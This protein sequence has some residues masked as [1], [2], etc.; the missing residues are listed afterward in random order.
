MTVSAETHALEDSII[1]EEI[2]AHLEQELKV[3]IRSY[4]AVHMGFRNWKWIVITQ[5]GKLFV[6]C[7]HPK[8]YP[9]TDVKCRLTIARS[10]SIQQIVHEQAKVCPAILSQDGKFIFESNSGY[11]YVV[12]EHYEGTTPAGAGRLDPEMMFRFGQAAGRMHSV[13][14]RHPGEGEPWT[15]TLETMQEKWKMQFERAA[16]LPASKTRLKRVLERQGQL[17][18][19]LDLSIFHHLEPGWAHWDLWVDNMLV[20]ADGDVCFVDFDTIQFGYQEIDVA[21]A[22]LSAALH[23]G[24]LRLGPTAAFLRGYREER[25]FPLGRLS[26]SLKLLWC[27]EAHWWLKTEMDAFSAPPKRFAEE[28]IWLMEHWDYL[29]GWFGPSGAVI[30]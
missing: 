2:F 8:R 24:Q 17:L 6:K 15:P 11:F 12:M 5:S 7:Y 10:L 30:K 28:M 19:Q 13:L 29:D 14:S 26:L 22:I 1:R 16:D 25:P 27:R 23:E 18:S 9:L 21:R 4:S 3:K 20:G